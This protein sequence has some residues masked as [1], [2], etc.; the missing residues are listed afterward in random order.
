MACTCSDDA[1][2]LLD[3]CLG[4]C[5]SA[6]MQIMEQ[7]RATKIED[8]LEHNFGKLSSRVQSLAECLRFQSEDVYKQAFR[9]GFMLAKEIY[10]SS[11]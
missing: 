11:Y 1:G 7:K 2:V 3:N 10:E 4:V 6:K 8:I 5:M 9:D